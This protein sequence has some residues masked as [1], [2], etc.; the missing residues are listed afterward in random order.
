RIL[1][2]NARRKRAARRGGTRARVDIGSIEIATA[3]KEDDLLAVNDALEKLAL[4]DPQ[5]AQL[6]K[7]RYFVGLTIEEASEIM[8]ISRATAKRHWTYARAWL[9]REIQA[10][11]E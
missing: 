8:D 9:Y 1:I 2:E 3:V 5:K 11:S 10:Q 4:R 6:V 7:L